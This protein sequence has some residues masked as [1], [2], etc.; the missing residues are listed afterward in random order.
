MNLLKIQAPLTMTMTRNMA[1]STTESILKQDMLQ[2]FPVYFLFHPWFVL[3]ILCATFFSKFGRVTELARQ[4]QGFCGV[5]GTQRD[6]SSSLDPWRAMSCR[7]KTVIATYSTKKDIN[8]CTNCQIQS[9]NIFTNKGRLV[10][11]TYKMNFYNTDLIAALYA[12]CA[13]SLP[14]KSFFFAAP[15]ARSRRMHSI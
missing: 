6:R 1:K 12:I 8:S 10:I 5:P 11:K 15:A 3:I 4:G 7:I 13:G 2:T 9:L 14:S